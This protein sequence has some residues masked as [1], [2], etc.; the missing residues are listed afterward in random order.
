M[1][2]EMDKYFN[3]L[4]RKSN[5]SE[6]SEDNADIRI[7]PGHKN[8]NEL[9]SKKIKDKMLDTLP[10]IHN[11]LH[12][13]TSSLATMTRIQVEDLRD[14][15]KTWK[16]NNK[17][18]SKNGQKIFNDFLEKFK[19]INERITKLNNTAKKHNLVL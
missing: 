19:N 8:S 7:T 4:H 9:S 14:E 12:P 17:R 13:S 15:L 3:D 6:I 1:F 16:R 18:L 11:I 10:Y 2:E 5:I